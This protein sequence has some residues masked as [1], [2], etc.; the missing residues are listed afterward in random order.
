MLVRR[1]LIA[2]EGREPQTSEEIPDKNI[3]FQV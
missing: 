2:G 1:N 3:P